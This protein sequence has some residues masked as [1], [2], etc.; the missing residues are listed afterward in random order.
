[1]AF[2]LLNGN[3]SAVGWQ[4]RIKEGAYKSPSGTRIP[5]SFTEVS[6][7][8]PLRRAEFSFNGL[9]EDYVQD[10]GHGSRRYPLVCYFNGRDH[11]KIATSFEA[12]LLEKGIG[13]LEHPLY[14]S[15][16]CIAVGSI[17]RRND[18]VSGNNQSVVEVTFSTTLPRV[19]PAGQSYPKSE[20]LAG[21]ND[22][23]LAAALSFSDNVR[24]NTV[25][26]QAEFK[27]TIRK[28]LGVIRQTFNEAQGLTAEVRRSYEEQQ[29]LINE[30]IDVLVG[31][32]LLLAQALTGLILA[33]ARTLAGYKARL[34]GYGRMLQ[35]ILAAFSGSDSGPGASSLPESI[36]AQRNAFYLADFTSMTAVAGS[37]IS[38]TD[39]VY[40]TRPEALDAADQIL[41]QFDSAV[42]WR[43]ERMTELSE[44]SPET[45]VEG[46]AI[47][48][49]GTSYQTLQESVAQAAGFLV[50]SSFQLVPER[51]VVLERNRTILDLCGQLYGSTS[52]ERLGF[53]IQSNDLS[54]DQI[55][56]LKR[57]DKILYYV[58]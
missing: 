29:A 6:R 16:P 40:R 8:T 3:G 25:A 33:P 24:L 41:T 37:T 15:F 20:I 57:G 7:E 23:N 39:S 43:D 4:T 18:L 34:E 42:T 10:N 48:D 54:G 11:D 51:A 50:E 53:L 9:N 56:E 55:L 2:D 1:M 35:G 12:A 27:S 36:V 47:I 46:G 44:A 26:R 32:P 52:N 19:Y 49:I 14:G 58:A 21:I 31:Q 45:S 30:S 17:T 22:F 5:F 28:T 13:T 38:S